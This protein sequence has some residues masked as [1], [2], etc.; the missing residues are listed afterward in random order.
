MKIYEPI[1]KEYNY[2]KLILSAK[3]YP[4][5]GRCKA[6]CKRDGA[7]HI[8]SMTYEEREELFSIVLPEWE[9]AVNKLSSPHKINFSILGN[10]NPHLHAHLIPRYNKKVVLYEEVFE[11]PNPTGNYAPYPKKKMSLEFMKKIE[12]DY[13]SIL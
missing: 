2:W 7:E 8:T 10:T 3:Q 9:R 13:K 11:D 6:L 12:N 1:L 4:Y 5:V